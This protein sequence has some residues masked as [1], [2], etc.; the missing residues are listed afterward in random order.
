MAADKMA[1]IPNSRSFEDLDVLRG[2]LARG[3][4]ADHGR[5]HACRLAR[6]HG[7]RR[8]ARLRGGDARPRPAL[9][10]RERLGHELLAE[11]AGVGRDLA[12]PRGRRH[13]AFRPERRALYPADVLGGDRRPRRRPPRSGVDPLV[14]VHLRGAAAE[15]HRQRDHAVAVPAPDRRMRAGRCQGRL[16]LSQQRARADRG[17]G[18]RLRQ[19]PHARHARQR[20]RARHRQRLHGQGRRGVHAGAER[21]RSSTASPASA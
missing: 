1:V 10:A 20:R 19:L 5:A 18:A 14:P 6:L 13:Q 4:C 17:E 21:H 16:P 9:R 2:R 12:R 7:V 11:A 15:A 8:R 3:Q